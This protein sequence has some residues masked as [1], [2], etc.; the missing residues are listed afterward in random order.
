VIVGHFHNS[1]TIAIVADGHTGLYTD[2]T[3]VDFG[4]K[5]N[6]SLMLPVLQNHII[7]GYHMAVF[8]FVRISSLSEAKPM[9]TKSLIYGPM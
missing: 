5:I 7:R 9:L 1:L 3:L 6:D 2:L 4:L 8:I